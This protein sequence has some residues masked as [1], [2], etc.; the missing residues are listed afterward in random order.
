MRLCLY[1]CMSSAPLSVPVL[2][3]VRARQVRVSVVL[4]RHVKAYI[5]AVAA[6]VLLSL[7]L[8]L[9]VRGRPPPPPPRPCFRLYISVLDLWCDMVCAGRR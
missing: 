4:I 1:V 5:T 2:V 7:H 3:Y 9:L 8:C 6:L